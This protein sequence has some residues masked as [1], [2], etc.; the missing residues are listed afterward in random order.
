MSVSAGIFGL[1]CRVLGVFLGL[2]TVVQ[3][4]QPVDVSS[5]VWPQD[6]VVFCFAAGGAWVQNVGVCYHWVIFGR[7]WAGHR[8]CASS[9]GYYG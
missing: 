3:C 7:W 1:S 5:P 4:Y 8:L 6:V 9:A 2:C